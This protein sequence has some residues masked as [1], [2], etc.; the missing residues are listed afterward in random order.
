MQKGLSSLLIVLL[1]ST[2]ALAS[3]G[4]YVYTQYLVNTT[5]T[6]E[7]ADSTSTKEPTMANTQV[8]ELKTDDDVQI[9]MDALLKSDLDQLESELDIN[10][11]DLGI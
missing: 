2:L 11:D 8:P 5:T 6:A 3:V 7:F 9:E 4:W 10:I 1:I